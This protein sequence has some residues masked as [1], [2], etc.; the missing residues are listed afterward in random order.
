MWRSGSGQLMTVVHD[1]MT[2]QTP[3]WCVQTDVWSACCGSGV[4]SAASTV[5][6]VAVAGCSTRTRF[7]VID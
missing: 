1:L 4:W 2:S 7:A 6:C 5:L 3:V